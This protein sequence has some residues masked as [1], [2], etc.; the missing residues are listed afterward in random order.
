MARFTDRQNR[1]NTGNTGRGVKF[2][3][4][5]E[6]SRLVESSEIICRAWDESNNTQ[7]RDLTWNLMGMG[8]NPQFRVKTTEVAL[9]GNGSVRCAN[10]QRSQEH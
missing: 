7:P 5:V 6:R 8:N 9:E 1:R 4:V 2:S 3:K 10:T